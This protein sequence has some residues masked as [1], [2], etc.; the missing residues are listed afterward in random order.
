MKLKKGKPMQYELLVTIKLES[1][2]SEE[3]V[4]KKFSTLFDF[5][6]L[7]PFVLSTSPTFIVI[8]NRVLKEGWIGLLPWNV[9]TCSSSLAIALTAWTGC[10][11]SK[12]A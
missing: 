11:F 5:G 3:I 2:H 10:R 12:N 1:D 7:S 6:T 9:R 4:A 8:Q